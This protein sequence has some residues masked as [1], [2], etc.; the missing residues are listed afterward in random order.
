MYKEKQTREENLN[1]GAVQGTRPGKL[2]DIGKVRHPGG[3]V[4]R[5][6]R[7]TQSF[8]VKKRYRRKKNQRRRKR[9]E[10]KF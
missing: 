2:Q 4:R 7:T 10:L 1:R 9:G 6:E 8:K 5:T 3:P